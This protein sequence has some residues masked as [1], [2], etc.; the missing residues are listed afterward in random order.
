[1]RDRRANIVAS[2]IG[3]GLSLLLAEAVLRIANIEYAAYPTKFQFGWPDSKTLD[4]DFVLD[5]VIQ[6]KPHDYDEIVQ[7]ETGTTIDVLHMGD[8]CTQLSTYAADLKEL[9]LER[10][11]QRRFHNLK[12]GAAGWSSFQGLQQMRR[13]VVAL[14]PRYVTIYFGW[15]DHWLSYG[16]PDKELDFSQARFPLY[17]ILQRARVFQVFSYFYNRQLQRRTEQE[18]PL[19]VSPED[20][21]SNLLEMVKVARVNGITPILVT[22]PS[23][24]RQGQE[25]VY[26]RDRFLERLDELVPLHHRY[27]NIMRDVARERNVL[28]LDLEREFD[29][30]PDAIVRDQYMKSDGIHLQ[31]EGSKAIAEGMYRFIERNQLL[32]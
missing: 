14:Q 26:L 9:M 5:P 28:L 16:L 1:M 10:R 17:R 3:I 27:T 21:R 30:L 20:Y 2:L 25:P 6:W 32:D 13:D 31:P 12:L 18:R 22:A 8:S 11:P 29:A 19:R 4:T 15:N 23:S 7:A 24:H